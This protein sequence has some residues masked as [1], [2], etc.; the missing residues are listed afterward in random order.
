MFI[1]NF[2]KLF[3]KFNEIVLYVIK[4]GFEYDK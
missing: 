4:E 2:I 3:K 1:I